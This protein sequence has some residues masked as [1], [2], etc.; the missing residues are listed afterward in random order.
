MFI[1]RGRPAL[2]DRAM[3]AVPSFALDVLVVEDHRD[4]AE[5]LGLLLRLWGHRIRIA[6]NGSEALELAAVSRP[7]VVFL[8][9]A[10]PGMDGW[11][12][13]QRLRRMPGQGRMLVAMVSGYGSREDRAHSQAAGCD[14][15]L[16]KP[17]D[18]E[19]IQRLLDGW[20]KEVGDR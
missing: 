3:T 15:H 17:V 18:P 4:T 6:R 13:A 2:L 14:L 20:R 8:D 7:D 5:S 9:L 11:E 10:L 16:I 19:V 1:A 12:V